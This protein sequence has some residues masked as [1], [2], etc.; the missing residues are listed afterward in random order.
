MNACK[1]L[2]E[3]KKKKQ[4]AISSCSLAPTLI[5]ENDADEDPDANFVI[6]R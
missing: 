2:P 1:Y 4:C 5:E 3:G 6:P